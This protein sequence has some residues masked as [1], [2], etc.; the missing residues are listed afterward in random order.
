MQLLLG[1]FLIVTTVCALAQQYSTPSSAPALPDALQR[2]S[3]ETPSSEATTPTPGIAP[4]LPD[5][6]SS[7]T[8][9]PLIDAA[10]PQPQ[11]TA[12]ALA[13]SHTVG[14]E[15]TLRSPPSRQ[16]FN[17]ATP[18]LIGSSSLIFVAGASTVTASTDATRSAKNCPGASGDK[19]DRS[20]W[21]TSLLSI[22]S[23]GPGYC[24]LGEGGFWKRGTY[25][26]TRAFAAH[27]YD[28]A[29]S[30]NSSQLLNRALTPGLS[31]SYSAY[32]A[33]AYQ[34]DAGERLATRY[35]TAVGRDALKNMFREFWPDVYSHLQHRHP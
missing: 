35:A 20:S 32:P 17:F 4:N 34:Y 10:T 1:L 3:P 30:F 21:V 13:N 9:Q 14:V 6:P 27:R 23:K 16:F 19:T 18:N 11:R 25:A 7:T 28:G 5:A 2:S 26:W 31:G 33:Y 12:D 22:T 24:A 15:T 29:N 8:R